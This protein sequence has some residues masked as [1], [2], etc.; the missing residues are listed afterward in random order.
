MTVES[1]EPFDIALELGL[2]GGEGIALTI[3][4]VA[5]EEKLEHLRDA[6]GF[7]ERVGFGGH[8]VI[9][10]GHTGDDRHE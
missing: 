5:D 10:D 9:P 4:G 6:L 2:P 3:P 1:V 8:H 7:L